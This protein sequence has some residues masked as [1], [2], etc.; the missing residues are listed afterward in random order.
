MAKDGELSAQM[1]ELA[2]VT[3]ELRA[4]VAALKDSIDGLYKVVD[5]VRINL[6]A[7]AEARLIARLQFPENGPPAA[8]GDGQ[9]I[10]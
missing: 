10:T 6:D 9:L 4:A 8:G 2:T 1:R 5:D 7:F 3:S